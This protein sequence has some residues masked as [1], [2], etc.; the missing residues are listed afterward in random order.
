MLCIKNLLILFQK[1]E[2][3]AASTRLNQ[4]ANII[5][6]QVILIIAEVKLVLFRDHEVISCLMEVLA[7]AKVLL[8]VPVIEKIGLVS[9]EEVILGRPKITLGI[10]KR[11]LP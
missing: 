9:L 2:V 11:R 5:L 10:S 3:K 4:K 6:L 1:A 8:L 7:E